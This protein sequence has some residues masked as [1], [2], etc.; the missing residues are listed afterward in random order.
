MKIAITGARGQLGRELARVL[1]PKHEMILL[2]RPKFDITDP[3]CVEDLEQLAPE[4]V[5]HTAAL[6]DV[7]ACAR[8]PVRAYQVNVEGTQN[9]AEGCAHA[10][11]QL[12]LVSTNEIFDGEKESPYLENDKPNPINPYGASKLAAEEIAHARLEEVYVVRTAWLY[13]RGGNKFPDKIISAAKTRDHSPLRVVDDELGNPTYAPDLARALAQLIETRE[14]G[15][16]HLVNEGVASRYD[17]ACRVLARAGVNG[18][19][20]RIKLKDYARDSVP[21]RNG[22]LE[23]RNAA[24][25]GIRLRSWQDAL[26]EF[27]LDADERG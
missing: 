6:T 22:A 12:L 24:E 20:T 5:I 25:L 7:D 4:L 27:F 17:W 23:N 19:V 2:A 13:A 10:H 14:F 3:L 15:D 11:A 26:E 18:A 21:P 1:A 16:Y 8:E 9:I